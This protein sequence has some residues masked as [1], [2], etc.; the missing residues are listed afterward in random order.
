MKIVGLNPFHG[1]ASASLLRDGLLIAA[2]EEERLNRIKHWAGLPVQAAKVCLQGIQLLPMTSLVLCFM[3]WSVISEAQ[4]KTAVDS[5]EYG[6]DCSGSA[7]S[8]LALDK[9]AMARSQVVVPQ[10]CVLRLSTSKT[11]AVALEFEQGGQL[12]PDTGITIMLTGTI[13]SG[14]QQIFSGAGSIDFTGNTGI[15]EVYPE[16]WGASSSASAA[17]NTH[18]LQAAV[19]AAF[20]N[21]NRTNGSNLRQWNK[22]L[23]LCGT[24]QINGELQFHHVSGFDMHG[25]A[26]MASGIVQT[27]ANKRIIDGQ[28]IAHGTIRNLSFSTTASQ[29]GP[30]V[31]LDNDH[32]QGADLS[33]QN[34]T[35]EDDTFRGNGSSDVGVLIAKHGGDAQGDNIRCIH[36]YFSGFSGAGWQVGGN[37]TGRNAG[38]F[39][40]YNAIKQLIKGGDCQ[41]N[42]LYCIA[43]YGGS[44]EVDGT[45]ME[46][47]SLGFGTQTGYD[48][49]CE[50]PQDR[51]VMRNVRSESHKL[52]SG[53]GLIEHSRTLFQASSWYSVSR[54]QSMAGTTGYLNEIFSGTGQGGDGKYYKVT[55]AGTFG[56]L[57]LTSA[58]GGSST[59]IVNWAARWMPG[60][61]VGQQATIVGGTGTGEYCIITANSATVITCAAGW[62]TNYYHLATVNPDNTSQFVVEPNWAANPTT[63]GTVKFVLSDFQVIGGCTAGGSAQ[64]NM[65]NC[66]IY[67]VAAPG[68]TS[69]LGGQMSRIENFFPSRTD[70]AGNTPG[71]F[72]VEDSIISNTYR[73]ILVERPDSAIAVGGTQKWIPWGFYRNSG[74]NSFYSGPTFAEV[75]TQPICWSYGGNG[76]GVSA[77]DV[78]I[79]IRT[80]NFS[81]SSASRAVLGFMGTL[82]PVTPFGLDKNGAINR[83]QGGLPTGNGVPG[84]IAFST[85]NASGAPGTSSVTDGT[86]RWVIQGATGNLLAN[87]D[88]T[89]DIGAREGNR[90]RDIWLGRNADI[91]GNLTVHGRCIGCSRGGDSLTSEEREGPYS[92]PWITASSASGNTSALPRA[93]N[94]AVIYGVVL[95][96]P[97][98]TTQL[99]Y[100]VTT[101]DAS[102]NTYDIGIYDNTGKLRVH[103]GAA[104]GSEAMTAG[105]HSA[106]W[107]AE[108]TL[109]PG[110]YYLAIAS[111]C[112]MTCAQMAAMNANGVTFLSNCE[113]TVT[114]RGSLNPNI[115]PPHDTFSFGSTIPAWIVQ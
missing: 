4:T 3:I 107:T 7:A 108:A 91:A 13:I 18:A 63:N 12:K 51:C 37:N 34:I 33:P 86:D 67:D 17:A 61:F 31:D 93:T 113:V 72:Q 8:D 103:T 95:T 53:V 97:L 16:W 43:V 58:T 94:K 45:T 10:S 28:N 38:R 114:E 100:S 85:G 83:L 57:G 92:I 55:T 111:S 65:G 29:T 105:V 40:A 110:K 56:G 52:A 73:N 21:Q 41:A 42:P 77:N 5:R 79:G 104:A 70:W 27:A 39:Y 99:T 22:S 69:N 48:V 54:S 75:G 35:F 64:G 101:A 115:T 90:P 1:D 81:T 26:K 88:N 62:V 44:I 87:A 60:A 15:S 47:D 2:L 102:A 66:L 11:Y 76:G 71:N 30:L 96:F 59:T 82:G 98:T 14:R 109:E 20:G 78:C 84:D 23:A 6:I 112:T 9:A 49:Y 89:Y 50:A 80:D 25:C 106:R 36:C 68:G 19:F 74:G 46:D 32:T 24:Y